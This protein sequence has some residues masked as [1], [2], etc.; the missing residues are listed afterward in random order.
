MNF[1]LQEISASPEGVRIRYEAELT[2]HLVQD[3]NLSMDDFVL[4]TEPFRV[5]P[6]YDEQLYSTALTCDISTLERLMHLFGSYFAPRLLGSGVFT[7]EEEEA[8]FDKFFSGMIPFDASK[9]VVKF[10]SLGHVTDDVSQVIP[11]HAKPEFLSSLS[12][13]DF[14]RWGRRNVNERGYK[15][16]LLRLRNYLYA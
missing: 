13:I 15:E 8:H 9:Y 14:I 10:V 1:L 4:V 7:Y 16:A 11:Y 6:L 5:K 3:S 2:L 12:W